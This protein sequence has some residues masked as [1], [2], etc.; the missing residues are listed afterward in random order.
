MRGYLGRDSD[1]YWHDAHVL[2]LQ[3]S[4]MG[5]PF[6]ISTLNWVTEEGD[7]SKNSLYKLS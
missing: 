4:T 3:R 2:K 5:S 1:P 7:V 6:W